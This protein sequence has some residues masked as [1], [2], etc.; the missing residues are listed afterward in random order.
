MG[1]APAMAEA[2]NNVAEVVWQSDVAAAALMARV[3]GNI[4]A[5]QVLLWWKH[6]IEMVLLLRRW[7][8]STM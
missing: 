3:V 6:L 2:Q 8:G 1:A 4:I 5:S 7:H